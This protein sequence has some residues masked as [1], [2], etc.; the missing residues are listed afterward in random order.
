MA[1]LCRDSP[2]DSPGLSPVSNEEG[3]PEGTD[4]SHDADGTVTWQQTPTVQ[5]RKGRKKKKKAEGV[6]L[7]LCRGLLKVEARGKWC[8][9][10]HMVPDDVSS[11]FEGLKKGLKPTKIKANWF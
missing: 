3:N 11:Y 4:P 6:F 2:S 8:S 5:G 1:V 10:D 9:L 7:N